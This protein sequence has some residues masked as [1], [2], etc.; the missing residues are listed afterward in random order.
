LDNYRPIQAKLMTDELY[1]LLAG[2]LPGQ[3]LGWITGKHPEHEEEEKGYSE[4][5]WKDRKKAFNDVLQ[6]F[7]CWVA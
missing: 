6:H 5:N 1:I 3:D 2:H 7:L 4:Q